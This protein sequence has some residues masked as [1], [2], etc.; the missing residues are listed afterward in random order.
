MAQ[1]GIFEDLQRKIDE[2]TAIKD[3]SLKTSRSE[4]RIFSD[5][6]PQQL[7]DIVQALEKQ[8]QLPSIGWISSHDGLRLKMKNRSNDPID[9]LSLALY[10]FSTA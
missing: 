7:R 1:A 2:D 3:V 10:T 9:P 8:G 4:A 5:M 6:I